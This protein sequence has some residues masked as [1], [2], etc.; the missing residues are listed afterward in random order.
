[1][2]VMATIG[3]GGAG[4]GSGGVSGGV[5]MVAGVHGCLG[6]VGVLVVGHA[7]GKVCCAAMAVSMRFLV[8]G[9]FAEEKFGGRG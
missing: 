5:A 4:D 6:V 3:R 1:M 8:F 7:W 9:D 2:V